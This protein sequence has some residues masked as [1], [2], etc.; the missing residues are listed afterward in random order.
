MPRIHFGVDTGELLGLIG[1]P[2]PTW[3]ASTGGSR[4]TRAPAGSPG[5]ALQ[6][7][8]DPGL[9]RP[10]TWSSRAREVLAAAGRA[11]HIFNLGHG[12]LPDTDPDMLAR[13]VDLVHAVSAARA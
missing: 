2:A 7:N 9:S 6:G 10:G 3:S 5:N 1:E 8:L 12:V 13:L 11:G 4:S